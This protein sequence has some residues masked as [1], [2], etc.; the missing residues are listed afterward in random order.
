MR[1]R[2]RLIV[3]AAGIAASCVVLSAC[4]PTLGPVVIKKT[5]SATPSASAAP[6]PAPAVAARIQINGDSLDVFAADGSSLAHF[7]YLAAPEASV[8]TL[9]SLIPQAPAVSTTTI[10]GGCEA[11]HHKVEW[12]KALTVVWYVEP[13]AG[14]GLSVSS[15]ARDIGQVKVE[16]PGGFG[17]GDSA[18]ALLAGIPGASVNAEYSPPGSISTYMDYDVKGGVG[19]SVYADTPDGPISV[20]S[21]PK[22]IEGDC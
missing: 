4:T 15:M 10:A 18:A 11:P 3:F 1:S 8:A 7:A 17:V 12:G 14:L 2:V 21:A 22:A 6:T 9:S 13:I 20:I 16:T 5:P 19:V